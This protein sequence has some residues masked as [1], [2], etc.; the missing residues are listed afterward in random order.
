MLPG[1]PLCEQEATTMG[2]EKTMSSQTE[3][4]PSLL[5]GAA[6]TA[7]PVPPAAA[8][9]G[10]R[11]L[12][13]DNLRILLICGVVVGH[14]AVTYGGL[15]SW[16]YHDPATN[17]LT[18]IL[19]TILTGIGIATG[20]GFFFLIAGYFTPGPYDRKGSASFLRDRLVRLGIPLLLYD[21]LL[22]PLV[23]Y[24]ASG[25]HG[26][27]WNFYG[28]YLLHVGMIG[29]GPVWF[30]E[31][32]LLFSILYVAWRGLTRQRPQAAARTRKLPSYRAIFGFVFALGLVSFVVR[33][34]WPMIL[35]LQ[36]LN[37][38]AAYV[39]QY[40]SLYILGLIA[41]RRNWFFELSPKMGR[42]WLRI[43]LIALLVPI[44]VAILFMVLGAQVA[45]TQS[46]YFL[47]GFHWQA[48]GEAVWE[49]FMVVGVCIGLLVLFRQHWN[50]Q[51]RLAKGLAANAYTVY[52]I[53]P[54]VLVSFAYAFQ[55]VALY[56]LLKFVIAVLITLPLCF[57]ISSFI[58]KIPLASRI[59]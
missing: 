26:A 38:P 11:L 57:L 1:D 18:S 33:I 28:D 56:P 55:A 37:L 52:L 53:H 6:G 39:P 44:L 16:Y 35:Q 9:H 54:L 12:F 15:G 23:V 43:T 22:D 2:K 40:I 25:L 3:Q 7:P 59:L 36:P 17:L 51:G 14:L 5:L 50:R 24:I 20:M 29:S 42:D 31:V 58:R 8:P 34:W 41:Y 47:G 49:S 19:L 27:Y 4:A 46:G 13:I 45:G 30:I 48:L 32:L 10:T 21:L